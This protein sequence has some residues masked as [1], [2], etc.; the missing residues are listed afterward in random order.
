MADPSPMLRRR[1]AGSR[2]R[3]LR[4]TAGKSLADVAAYL[5]CSA[6][7]VSRVE[8]GRLLARVPDVRNMLD[9]YDV[10]E[11]ERAEILDMVRESRERGW[12]QDYPDVVYDTYGQAL[13]YEDSASEIWQYEEYLVP[14][15]LQTK[16]YAYAVVAN[17]AGYSEEIADRNIEVRM[18][19]QA[20]LDRPEPPRFDVILDESVL[21]RVAAL[22]RNTGRPQ[23]HRFA[24]LAGRPNIVL[25]VVP[26]SAGISSHVSFTVFGFPEPTDPRIACV[27][28]V[29]EVMIE[30]RMGAV[31]QYVAMFDTARFM[32]LDPDE[33]LALIKK[34]A[35]TR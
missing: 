1:R 22:G 27:D 18:I 10:S 13:G 2:L 23:L 35:A 11:S 28:G 12:W 24:E 17:H 29:A 31:A 6:A 32:A 25:R 33:S 30:S 34:V 5:E 14:G 4:E 15:L 20:I 9:L 19:R 7:K 8:T 21:H 26:Y 16:E 3:Q